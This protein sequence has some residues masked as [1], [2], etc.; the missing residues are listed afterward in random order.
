MVSGF[1]LAAATPSANDLNGFDGCVAITF[2]ASPISITGA[3]SFTVSKS[4]SIRNGLTACES[5]TNSQVLP[6]GGDFATRLVPRLPDEPGRFS[7]TI[8]ALSFCCRPGCA[9]RAIG[10]TLPPGGNGTMIL[11]MPDGQLSARAFPASGA[12]SAPR[13]RDRRGG[14][15]VVSPLLT[16][17]FFTSSPAVPLARSVQNV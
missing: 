5:N 4:R 14:F 16:D 15:I 13:T 7:I 1:A 11:M 6:S 10:S 9:M 8:L 3:K 2:G 17:Y 12:A